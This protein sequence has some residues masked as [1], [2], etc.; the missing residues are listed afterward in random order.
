MLADEASW[1]EVTFCDE[2]AA[3]ISYAAATASA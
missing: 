3:P 1:E 2:S